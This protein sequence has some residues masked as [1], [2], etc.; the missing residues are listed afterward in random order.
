VTCGGPIEC[1]L[2]KRKV[3][4]NKEIAGIVSRNDAPAQ[5][6]FRTSGTPRCA[7]SLAAAN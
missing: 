7:A 1:P 3:D 2:C 6:N 4:R 5:L